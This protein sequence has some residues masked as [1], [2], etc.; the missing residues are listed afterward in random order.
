MK[1]EQKERIADLIE[2]VINNHKKELDSIHYLVNR[3]KG[4]YRVYI[5]FELAKAP[6]VD[7]DLDQV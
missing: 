7:R 1:K 4:Q 6:V 3:E 5:T 2:E